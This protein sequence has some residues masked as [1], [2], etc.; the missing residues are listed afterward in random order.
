MCHEKGSVSNIYDK[1][2]I[3]REVLRGGSAE[4]PF[5]HISR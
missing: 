4:V 2:A 5:T 1:Y 3:V